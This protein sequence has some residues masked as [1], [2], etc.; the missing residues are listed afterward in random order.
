MHAQAR[1]PF[2][3]PC[4]INMQDLAEHRHFLA[5][6]GVMKRGEEHAKKHRPGRIGGR[7]AYTSKACP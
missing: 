2:Y 4:P 7:V 6:C 5:P 3:R 1:I